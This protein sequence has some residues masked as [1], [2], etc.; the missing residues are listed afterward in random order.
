MKYLKR[1]ISLSTALQTLIEDFFHIIGEKESQII[2]EELNI[3]LKPLREY[4]NCKERAVIL[5]D[6]KVESET[7]TLDIVPL[8]CEHE[9]VLKDK[10]AHALKLLR[11]SRF[12]V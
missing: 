2:V 7:K 4:R 8:L 11:G 1:F 6:I 10:I 5:N 9:E 12:Y 3:L